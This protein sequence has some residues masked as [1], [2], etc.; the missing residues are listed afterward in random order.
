MLSPADRSEF[1]SCLPTTLKTSIKLC[2]VVINV[3]SRKTA[4]KDLRHDSRPNL[5]FLNQKPVN[6]RTVYAWFARKDKCQG[7]RVKAYTDL[8]AKIGISPTALE[9]RLIP[10]SCG[11]NRSPG[12]LGN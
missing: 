11:I 7:R 6:R 12:P 1:S 8:G 4:H 3:S 10:C 2:E 5:R 9:P